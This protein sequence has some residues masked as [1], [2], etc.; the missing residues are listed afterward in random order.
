MLADPYSA[1]PTR[2]RSTFTGY[3]PKEIVDN[4]HSLYPKPGLANL[5]VT[6]AVARLM[7]ELNGE[8][9]NTTEPTANVE[10]IIAVLDRLNYRAAS[11][12]RTSP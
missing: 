6:T 7:E 11:R 3:V 5:I 2:D 12:K 1:Q 8:T 10:R 9:F 4:L